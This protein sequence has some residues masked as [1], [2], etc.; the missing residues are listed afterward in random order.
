MTTT[1]YS[2][3]RLTLPSCRDA[4]TPYRHALE[5]GYPGSE[6]A[7]VPS[8]LNSYLRRQGLVNS[9]KSGIFSVDWTSRTGE[10][11]KIRILLYVVDY[12]GTLLA[13]VLV[14][15]GL[16]RIMLTPDVVAVIALAAG[17]GL[18]IGSFII[19]KRLK[20][21]PRVGQERL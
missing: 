2:C 11:A 3:G 16:W 6:G 12:L 13:F 1:L 10:V 18:G 14:F 7:S 9:R 20:R 8:T 21:N 5:G 4:T 15:L 17:L 19:S